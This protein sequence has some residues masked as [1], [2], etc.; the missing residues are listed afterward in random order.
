[1]YRT[2]IM[3]RSSRS[4]LSVTPS[5]EGSAILRSTIQPHPSDRH[6]RSV[7]IVL[8]AL[9]DN[10]EFTLA[11]VQVFSVQ[12]KTPIKDT[13]RETWDLPPSKQQR[14]GSERTGRKWKTDTMCHGVEGVETS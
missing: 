2:C 4:L 12:K 9:W 8:V 3:G 11:G 14:D 10:E 5:A 1:M 13:Q 7:V 6:A